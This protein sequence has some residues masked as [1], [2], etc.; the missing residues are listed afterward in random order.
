MNTSCDAAA[1]RA[2]GRGDRK[3]FLLIKDGYLCET[4]AVAAVL[5]LCACARPTIDR[6]SG[7]NTIIRAERT[8]D[9][10]RRREETVYD[11]G[12]LCAVL[13]LAFFPARAREEGIPSAA[14]ADG[15]NNVNKGRRGRGVRFSL[16]RQ[17][18]QGR[19]KTLLFYCPDSV[20]NARAISNW[21]VLLPREP[22]FPTPLLWLSL[23]VP[24]TQVKRHPA[25][26]TLTEVLCTHFRSS[27]VFRAHTHTLQVGHKIAD[28]QRNHRESY[29]RF[30]LSISQP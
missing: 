28:I 3:W 15:G 19:A 29:P 14:V 7:K 13:L 4:A 18:K 24:R 27:Y 16:C 11:G 22:S 17:N 25:V 5:L 2:S 10:K 26:H 1:G 30:F 8:G 23:S 6:R 20:Y 12:R 9:K 21:R